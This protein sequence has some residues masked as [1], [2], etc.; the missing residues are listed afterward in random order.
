MTRSPVVAAV[1]LVGFL[2]ALVAPQ[3][4]ALAAGAVHAC[5]EPQYDDAGATWIKICKD[6]NDL[7]VTVIVSHSSGGSTVSQP[8]PPG[9]T[10]ECPVYEAIPRCKDIPMAPNNT[11]PCAGLAVGCPPGQVYYTLWLMTPNSPD[12][13]RVFVRDYCRDP[14][15]PPPPPPPPP[16]VVADSSINKYPP[17]RSTGSL[18]PKTGVPLPVH[19]PLY[20]MADRPAQQGGQDAADGVTVTVHFSQ[21]RYTWTFGDGSDDLVTSEPGAGYPTGPLTHPYAKAKT[22]PVT[23]HVDWFATYDYTIGTFT[24]TDVPYHWVPQPGPDQ[25]FQVPVVEAHAV[26]VG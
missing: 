24:R 8:P 16:W 23:L 6:A 9:C 2:L 18:Q 3:Q 7:P 13:M 20:V 11:A 5:S 10:G 12:T 4:P 1:A 15:Q 26:L 14:A 21:V 22:Y 19:L 17:T 25:A